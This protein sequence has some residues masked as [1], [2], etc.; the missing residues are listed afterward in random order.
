MMCCV[1]QAGLV[2]RRSTSWYLMLTSTCSSSQIVTRQGVNVIRLLLVLHEKIY[3]VPLYARQLRRLRTSLCSLT[4]SLLASTVQ[5]LLASALAALPT[6]LVPGL[7][8]LPQQ[9]AVIFWVL[10]A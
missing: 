4:S 10:P 8:V 2:A 5:L 1:L 6:S 9:Q 7:S 3:D